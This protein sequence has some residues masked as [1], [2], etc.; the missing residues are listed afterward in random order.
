MLSLGGLG[1][2]SARGEGRRQSAGRQGSASTDGLGWDGRM[3]LVVDAARGVECRVFSAARWIER[4]T[5]GARTGRVL[6]LGGE[7][8]ACKLPWE[9]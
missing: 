2:E 9:L 8:E 1:R 6:A 4:S 3:R 5:F 7:E